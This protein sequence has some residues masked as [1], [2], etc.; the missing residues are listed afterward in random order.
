MKL[1]EIDATIEDILSALEPDAETGEL[2]PDYDELCIR[3]ESLAAERE[4]VLKWLAESAL[5]A[6][7]EATMLK[8]EEQRLAQRRRVLENKKSGIMR[9]LDRELGGQPADLGICKVCYRKS[10]R[11]D[12]VDA[13]AAAKWLLENGFEEYIKIAEPEISKADVKKLVKNGMEIAGVE[14]IN[15][16]SCSLR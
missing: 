3:L 1:Y 7:A 15:S 11:L 4:N 12:V 14:L 9:V 8:G 6:D 5:N 16:V 13:S 10:D 2:N